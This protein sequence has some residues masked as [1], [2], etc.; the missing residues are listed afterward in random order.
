MTKSELQKKNPD[1]LKI[2]KGELISL[3]PDIDFNKTWKEMGYD[4][5]DV[6]EIVMELEKRLNIEITDREVEIL[7]DPNLKPPDFSALIRLDKL[8]KLG[9]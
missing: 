7:F 2:T 4:E 9:I 1:L 8:N 3:I 6:I 5:L